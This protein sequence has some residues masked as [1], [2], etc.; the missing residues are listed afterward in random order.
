MQ[1][2]SQAPRRCLAKLPPLLYV[3]C[4]LPYCRHLRQRIQQ[5][6]CACVACML[7]WI[8]FPT[9]PHLPM[10]LSPMPHAPA[11]QASTFYTL[12]LHS[13]TAQAP[14]L[15]TPAAQSPILHTPA[16]Q[17]P[18]LRTPA[19][20][21]PTFHTPAAQDPYLCILA[22]WPPHPFMAAHHGPITHRLR[23]QAPTRDFFT[24]WACACR[25]TTSG[26]CTFPQPN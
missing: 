2:K 14:T 18:T 16:A 3:S 24:A 26:V 21:V 5:L 23:S 10:G 7:P 9:A 4:R 15:C 22:S 6:A 20:Q 8:P 25:L 17:A 11:V 12:L 19:A 13:P 1:V